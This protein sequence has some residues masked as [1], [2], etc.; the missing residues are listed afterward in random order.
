[1]PPAR[2]SQRVATSRLA[3]RV[4][5][6][7]G[8]AAIREHSPGAAL[9][10]ERPSHRR[11]RAGS[12]TPPP[13]RGA[14]SGRRAMRSGA[15]P[16]T[17]W[18]RAAR[19]GCCA[20]PCDGHGG[21][22]RQRRGRETSISACLRTV[23]L[24]RFQVAPSRPLFPRAVLGQ[25]L[26]VPG[27][28]RLSGSRGDGASSAAL[29]SAGLPGVSS[30][31]L[32][33]PL[34]RGTLR[35]QGGRAPFRPPLRRGAGRGSRERGEAALPPAACG[36]ERCRRP[37]RGSAIAGLHPQR[38]AEP[39]GAGSR[40]PRGRCCLLGKDR[41]RRTWDRISSGSGSC[42]PPA[43]ASTGASSAR[44]ITLPGGFPRLAA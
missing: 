36:G 20:G 15:A 10:E 1:M 35:G 29:S 14:G 24:R 39:L 17:W 31:G 13:R 6:G 40:S 32:R 19:Q 3:R 12:A 16:P 21:V 7:G 42:S 37:E 2:I 28:E 8:N 30:A 18:E 11:G 4:Q 25:G 44:G 41:T 38:S 33:S 5:R 22:G 9:A 26:P 23:A 27:A 34:R 43:P